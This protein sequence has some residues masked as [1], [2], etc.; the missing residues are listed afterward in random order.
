MIIH[1][2]GANMHH[3]KDNEA[4]FIITSPPYFSDESELDLIKPLK[5]QT[6]IDRV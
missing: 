1:G 5:I 4:D 3:I 2:N 6:E